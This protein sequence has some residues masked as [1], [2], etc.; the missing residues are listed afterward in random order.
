MPIV[1]ALSGRPAAPRPAHRFA[2]LGALLSTAGFVS[3]ILAHSVHTAL[4]IGG[5]MSITAGMLLLAPLGIRAIAS[6]AGRA[7]VAP[8]LALRD[9]ARYQARSGAALA[10]ASLAVGIAATIA[11]T[12]A[13][14]QAND[15]SASVGNLPANQLIVWLNNP[16]GPGP[17][18]IDAVPTSGTGS[19]PQE[20]APA[21]VA[22][23]HATAESIASALGGASVT[24]LDGAVNLSNQ[25]PP[26]LPPGAGQANL[27]VPIQINGQ[28]GFTQV[29]MP[30]VATAAVLQLY[31]ISASAISHTADI[32]T[33]RTDLHG[34]ELGTG[35]G[36]R[37]HRD[38]QAVTVQVVHGLPI[39]TSVPNTLITQAGMAAQGLSPVPMGWLVQA[40]A[41]ITSAQIADAQHKAAAAGIT[42]ENRTGPDQSLQKVRE[43]ST[44]AGLLVA[45]GVLA[46]TVGLI[47]SE[48]AGDLRTLTATGAS[49]RTR[50]MLNAT[51]AGALAL[52]GG[53]LGV[54]TAYVAL[55]AWHWHDIDY[56]NRPPYPDLL[57]MVVGLPVLAMAGAWLLG[58]TPKT[59]G[60]SPTE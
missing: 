51:T 16:N 39:F 56:L 21:V 44:L 37:G 36:G 8:R 48:T 24:E 13:A 42:V 9:L 49:G 18:S 38:F 22:A 7:P 32:V 59:L 14:Q 52:L 40:H 3:L 19:T 6:F 50:R 58:R 1:T 4:I 31:G 11:I 34:T 53:I 41:P 28:H 30:F 33:S 26:G 20:P 2:V 60:R 29:A 45:L 10:A 12:A 27:V 35:F 23:A 57:V 47:R 46:M 43:Y 17:G 25:L 5:I 15:R 55:I 54:A